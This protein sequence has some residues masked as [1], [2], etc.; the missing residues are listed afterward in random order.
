M[1]CGYFLAGPRKRMGDQELAGAALLAWR[2]LHHRNPTRYDGVTVY[3]SVDGTT[4]VLVV[5]DRV[6]VDAFRGNAA[7]K[8]PYYEGAT[9]G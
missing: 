4:T 8:L 7:G 5:R 6:K 3:E 2:S 1:R 9:V